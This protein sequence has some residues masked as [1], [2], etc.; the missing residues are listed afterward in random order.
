MP[1]DDLH[2]SST[3]DQKP[4]LSPQTGACTPRFLCNTVTGSRSAAPD[5]VDPPTDVNEPQHPHPGRGRRPF[6]AVD[7]P[8]AVS[9]HPCRPYR[10][11]TSP[12]PLTGPRPNGPVGASRASQPIPFTADRRDR[13]HRRH[14]HVH[15]RNRLNT[16]SLLTPTIDRPV[17]R[18]HSEVCTPPARAAYIDT[19]Q[20]LTSENVTSSGTPDLYCVNYG[21]Y[22]A[23]TSGNTTPAGERGFVQ[24]CSAQLETVQRM[25][26]LPICS[27][28]VL[29]SAV[30]VCR[31]RSSLGRPTHSLVGL[32]DD[33]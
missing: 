4:H 30:I 33:V 13:L 23:L 10:H 8:V 31:Q 21:R 32:N 7:P 9:R 25:Y 26:L 1:S 28:R 24:S 18:Q 3:V 14:L 6:V 16:Q 29:P 5:R 17:R 22:Y 19:Y 2:R 27:P 12:S 20:G 15:L 11:R